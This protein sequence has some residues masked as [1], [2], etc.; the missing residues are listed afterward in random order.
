MPSGFEIRIAR[1]RIDIAAVQDLWRQYWTTSGLPPG[2]QGF[3]DEWRTLPGVYGEPDGLLLIACDGERP[4]G[5]IAL[6]RLSAEC[7][8]SGG[9]Y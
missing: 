3:A 4:A 2:F 8:D 6:R 1:D 7:G 5:T 9:I